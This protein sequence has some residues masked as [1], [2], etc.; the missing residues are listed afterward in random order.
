MFDV[1]IT[2]NLQC[3]PLHLGI[4]VRNLRPACFLFIQA[5]KLPIQHLENAKIAVLPC[6]IYTR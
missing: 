2:L 4:P 3:S 1:V 6:M 5:V